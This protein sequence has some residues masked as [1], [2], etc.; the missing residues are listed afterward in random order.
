MSRLT[1]CGLPASGSPSDGVD[2]PRA[3]HPLQFMLAA[4]LEHDARAGDEILHGLGDEHLAGACEA[5]HAGTRRHRDPTQLSLDPLALAGVEPGTDLQPE[6]A[7][8]LPDRQRALDRAAGAV[9]RREE[10]VAGGVELLA[11]EPR[12]LGPHDGVVA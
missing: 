2:A 10:A 1:P 4:L 6:R 7:N 5:R 9:E 11:A 12:Q 3:R 8:C